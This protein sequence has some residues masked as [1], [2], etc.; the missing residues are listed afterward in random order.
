MSSAA[1]LS[2][3][4]HS[5]RS[6]RPS[7]PPPGS[8]P[9]AAA[10]AAVATAAAAAVATAAAAASAAA[11]ADDPSLLPAPQ[12]RGREEEDD[13]PVVALTGSAQVCALMCWTR[14]PFPPYADPPPPA[15]VCCA[16]RGVRACGARVQRMPALPPPGLP[17]CH[18]GAPTTVHE[19]LYRVPPFSREALFAANFPDGRCQRRVVF[20]CACGSGVSCLDVRAARLR[21]QCTAPAPRTLSVRRRHTQMTTGIR[22]SASSLLMTH[23]STR[24]SSAET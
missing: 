7:P 1:A 14:V 16:A 11:A 3:P 10:A 22:S 20:G 8:S 12:A 2:P 6:P 17:P 23:C 15:P 5:R 13:G 9:A 4:D 19:P 18:M 21:R 24:I